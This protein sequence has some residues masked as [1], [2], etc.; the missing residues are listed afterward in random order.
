MNRCTTTTS[1]LSLLHWGFLPR[2]RIDIIYYI[3]KEIRFKKLVVA[4]Q[5]M[6]TE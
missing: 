6:R 3:E 2:K 1:K 4:D 5:I